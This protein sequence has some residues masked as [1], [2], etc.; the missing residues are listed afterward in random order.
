MK[1]VFSVRKGC[2]TTIIA[3]MQETSFYFIF[4]E[5]MFFDDD[6]DDVGNFT[7]IINKKC[8]T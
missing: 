3:T 2:F 6:D 4:S 5:L 7:M 8:N 1:N